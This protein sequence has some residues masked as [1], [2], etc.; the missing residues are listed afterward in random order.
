MPCFHGTTASGA[1]IH[2]CGFSPCYRLPLADGRRVFMEWHSYFGPAFYHDRAR[3]RIIDNWW[4][5]ERICQALDW[6]QGR[7]ERA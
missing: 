2:L 1:I 7:G 6:F 5:D 3:N 4:E